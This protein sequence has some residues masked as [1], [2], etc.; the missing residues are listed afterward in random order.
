VREFLMADRA[1]VL[2]VDDTPENIRVL[3]ETLRDDYAIVAATNGTKALELASREP[4]PDL[5]LLDV[6]MPDLDGYEVCARLKED[7][8][9]RNIPVI[10]V[11][12]LAEAGDEARGLGLGA[13]DY[14][15]KPFHPGLVKARVRNQ[16]EL[17]R[18]R[19]RLEDLVEERTR[20]L[21]AATA[22]RERL[23]SELQVARRLQMTMLP[24]LGR[25][26]AESRGCDVAAVV[27][28]ATA[29]GGDLYD[30]FFLDD[31]RL[32]F[33]IGDVSDKGAAAALFMV[34]T[35]TVAR[36]AA[37]RVSR[38]ARILEV[39]N[40]RL[41]RDNEACMFVTFACGVLDV[42]T[43]ELEYASGGH[44]FP[45]LVTPGRSTEFA[46]V[47]GGPALGL[48]PDATFDS[49]RLRLDPG[50]TLLLYTDGVTE[51]FDAI[52]T[53]FGEG[54]LLETATARP[55]ADAAA[56]VGRVLHAVGE[57]AGEAPQSDDIT[58]L[59]VRRLPDGAS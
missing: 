18:H 27:E 19:D 42:R 39:L 17:K 25:L 14:V 3:M 53:P 44:E 10:F 40:R 38:P 5:V 57:H 46:L 55:G 45:L 8:A 2:I 21:L 23:E 4:R 28:P 9:T 49:T 16:I 33:A 7:E 31:H 15:T 58:L 35:A 50:A 54:R 24:D 20:E 13:V 41:A 43:G 37:A 56:L 51:S 1:K 32:V 59:A 48:H 47:P 30:A 29:V 26:D 22:A 12:A 11:T 34:R 52:G 36:Y 6:M